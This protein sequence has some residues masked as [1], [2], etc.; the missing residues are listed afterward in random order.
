MNRP[1]LETEER[2]GMGLRGGSRRSESSRNRWWAIDATQIELNLSAP[3]SPVLC[4]L[5]GSNTMYPGAITLLIL[6]FSDK[7]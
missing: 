4:R 2:H 5:L 1:C 3:Y 6:F 7:R